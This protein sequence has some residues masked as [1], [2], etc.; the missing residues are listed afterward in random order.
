MDALRH[1]DDEKG[2]PFQTADPIFASDHSLRLVLWNKGAEALLG[3]TSHEV[4]GRPCHHLIG[5]RDSSGTLSCH[6]NCMEI[7]KARQELVPTFDH[8]V[9]KKGGEKI[10]LNVTTILA[11]SKVSGPWVLV[12]LL[13]DLTR[14]KEM[15]K[16]LHQVV[17]RAEE[18]ALLPRANPEVPF[19]IARSD[20]SRPLVTAREREVLQLLAQG[21]STESIAER[22]CITQRTARNHV[23]N[24]LDKLHVHSRLEAVAYASRNSLL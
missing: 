8:E 1:C 7:L 20:P 17:S 16:L 5:C 2:L 12:H 23:Q 6:G 10:W 11:P 22:L 24:V 15:E 4:L 13:R 3:F 21:A 14:Q 9:R 18:L 19:P